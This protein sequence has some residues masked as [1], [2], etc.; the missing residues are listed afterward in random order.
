[1]FIFIFILKI[2]I[3]NPI[4]NIINLLLY[5]NCHKI[6]LTLFIL[7]FHLLFF[8]LYGT[9]QHHWILDEII[10]L[11]NIQFRMHNFHNDLHSLIIL[12][13]LE[14]LQHNLHDI[15]KHLIYQLFYHSI[16]LMNKQVYD[17]S[18]YVEH[19]AFFMFLHLN[20]VQVFNV[21]NI[22]QLF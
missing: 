20:N 11:K 17:L 16:Q 1:M 19:E 18:I 12:H 15:N 2:S 7:N 3:H 9:I 14:V 6:L 13:F 5:S 4:L 21:Q 8:K 10:I 22:Y